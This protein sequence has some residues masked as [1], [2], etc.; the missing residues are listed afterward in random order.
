MITLTFEMVRNS[1]SVSFL[2]GLICGLCYSVAVNI[3]SRVRRLLAGGKSEADLPNRRVRF[4]FL[5]FVFFLLVGLVFILINYTFC[6]GVFTLYTL[7][8]FI[9]AFVFTRSVLVG[10]FKKTEK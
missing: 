1:I 2:F 10:I 3:R 6:D 8:S 4:N 9:S 7:I 5:E